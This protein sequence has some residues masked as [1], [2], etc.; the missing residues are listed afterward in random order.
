MGMNTVQYTIR[1]IPTTVMMAVEAQAKRTNRS[2]NSVLL[3]ALMSSFNIKVPS[4]TSWIDQY[5]T[6]DNDVFE[7]IVESRADYK[8]ISP[9]DYL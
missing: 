2:K 1:S 7:A 6:I 3:N 9:K 4:K 8:V 5:G